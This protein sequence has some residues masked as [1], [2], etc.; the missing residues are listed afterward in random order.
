MAVEDAPS[1][2]ELQREV[3]RLRRE[4]GEA[5]EREAAAGRALGEAQRREAEALEQQVA[6][7]EVLKVISRSA[8]DLE[9]V[10]DALVQNAAELCRAE[11]GV[12]YRFDGEV[13]RA[14]GFHGILP[15]SRDLF[16]RY[17]LAPGRGTL[18]GRVLLERHTVHLPDIRADEDF[19]HPAPEVRQLI[20]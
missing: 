12:I 10:L 15:A 18:V 8:F 2:A 3:V 4:L 11:I 1:H 14:V 17:E 7:A 16:E 20:E 13:A 9:A 19:E 5:R 6:T